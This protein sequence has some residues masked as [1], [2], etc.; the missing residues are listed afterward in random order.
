MR[1]GQRARTVREGRGRQGTKTVRE[2]RGQSG[3]EKEGFLMAFMERMVCQLLRRVLNCFDPSFELRVYTDCVG[4]K[5]CFP[6]FFC[7][8]CYRKSSI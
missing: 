5:Y 8:C 4:I 2:G 7:C 3:K 6:V 1:R